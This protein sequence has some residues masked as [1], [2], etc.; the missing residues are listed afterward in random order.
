MS[1][2]LERMKN[3]GDGECGGEKE[4]KQEIIVTQRLV[5]CLYTCTGSHKPTQITSHAPILILQMRKSGQSFS[6]KL[7]TPFFKII[8]IWLRRFQSEHVGSSS[9]T[10][11]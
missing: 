9:L 11:D 8:F 6:V 7:R 2:G 10:R 5:K 3:K 4:R 1:E